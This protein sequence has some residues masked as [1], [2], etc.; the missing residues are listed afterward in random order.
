MK[1]Y[2]FL[3]LFLIPCVGFTSSYSFLTTI[4]EDNF[5][6]FVDYKSLQKKKNIVKVWMYLDNPIEQ[7]FQKEKYF[8]IRNFVEIHCD[9]RKLRM[10]ETTYFE[11]NHLKGRVIFT[12]SSPTEFMNIPPNSLSSSLLDTCYL[13]K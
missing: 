6:V 3:I 10:L 9:D 8:S 4:N 5:D 12:T 7:S 11:K 13:K 1:R 2:I